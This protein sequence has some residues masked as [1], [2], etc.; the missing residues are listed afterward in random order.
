[1]KYLIIAVLTMSCAM[2]PKASCFEERAID[3][4]SWPPTASNWKG[5][6]LDFN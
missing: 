3:P 5:C 4:D 1:M 2:K 6:G